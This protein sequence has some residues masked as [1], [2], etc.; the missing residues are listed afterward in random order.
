[1]NPAYTSESPQVDSPGRL[2]IGKSAIGLG[3][4]LLIILSAGFAVYRIQPVAALGADAPLTEFSAA[5][6]MKH[7]EVISRR[8]RP[9]GSLEHAQARD[10]IIRTLEEAGLKPE[11]QRTTVAVPS[12]GGTARAGTV[13][14]IIARLGGA[15][16]GKAILISSHYDTVPNSPGA[17]DDGAGVVTSLETLRALKAGAP[18]KN[19]VIFLFTDGEEVGLLGAKAFV[20]EH[21]WAK[22]VALALNFDARGN[23]GVP[24]MFETSERNG[25][26]VEEFAEAAPRPVANSLAFEVYR[27]MPNS[28]D[29]TVFKEAGLAGMNFGYIGGVSHYHTSLDT[30]QDFD[31][32]SLQHQGSYALALARRFGDTKLEGLKETNSVYFDVLG[33]FLVR[34]STS[35]V[36]PL[37]LVLLLL[38][39]GVLALGFKRRQLTVAGIAAGVGAFVLSALGVYGLV[40]LAWWLTTKFLSEETSQW[41]TYHSDSY[42]LGFVALS[43]GVTLIIYAFFRKKVAVKNLAAGALIC[44]LC[45]TA[46][47][48]LYLPGASY[49]FM[50]PLLFSLLGLGYTF[51]SKDRD[52]L[53]VKNLAVLTACALPGIILLAPMVSLIYTGLGVGLAAAVMVLVALLLGLLIQHFDLMGARGR[54]LAPAAALLVGAGIVASS[55]LTARFDRSHPTQDNI[56][57][58]LES[59]S[60]KAVWASVDDKLDAWTTKVFARGAERK[61]L[62]DF[63]PLSNRKFLQAE[64]PAFA[65]AAPDIQLLESSQSDDARDLH[66]HVTSARQAPVI[67]LQLDSDA[68][69]SSAL[70]DGKPVTLSG[71]KGQTKKA[72]RWGMHYYAPL[73]EGFDLELTFRSSSPLRIKAIDQ[74]YGLPEMSG[75]TA[76]TRPD[77]TIPAPIG[78]SDATFVSKTYTF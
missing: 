30:F 57:Y 26:L 51:V 1:M 12:D 63:F 49:L 9:M 47:T 28:T 54:W 27:L 77:Y 44:W 58:G 3:V 8:P 64:A 42:L 17:S 6:A 76:P 24:I 10:Y 59:G 41:P 39:A 70:V 65:L 15:E 36:L 22:D 68:E 53:S 35:L 33:L 55:G 18:L 31:P 73:P 45:L 4:F 69:V 50:W 40:T 5:R 48:G 25:R 37:T 60:G 32:R 19:D 13:S 14:N 61:T 7:L 29:M 72:L 23:H 11:V 16:G 2:T 52:A 56:F 62:T 46:L 34:Y 38:F 67:Y 74:S 71:S 75:G 43:V 20:A 66:L 21:P 78:F